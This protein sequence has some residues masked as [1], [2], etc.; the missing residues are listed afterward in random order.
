MPNVYGTA[1]WSTLV[2][3]FPLAL[4]VVEPR[5]CGAL[6]QAVRGRVRLIPTGCENGLSVLGSSATC[7]TQKRCCTRSLV[8]VI[9]RFRPVSC[10]TLC[11]CSVLQGFP[12]RFGRYFVTVSYGDF[13]VRHCLTVSFCLQSSTISLFF[14]PQFTSFS[15]KSS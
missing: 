5:R 9:L 10:A 1:R 14:L 3:V 2:F 15:G 7:L 4:P 8:T 13:D 11:V 12:Q 6:A